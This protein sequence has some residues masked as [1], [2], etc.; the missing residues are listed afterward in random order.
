MSAETCET[1]EEPLV[2]LRYFPRQLITADCMRTEQ[3]YFLD[4]R[5]RHNRYLHGFG[6]SC[7]LDVRRPPDA[8]PER[9][10]SKVW[11][12]PGYAVSPE[13]DDILLDEPVCIDLATGRQQ[14][15]PCCEPWPCPPVGRLPGG[16]R[17]LLTLWLAVRYA[18]CLSRP[19]RVPA[20]GCGCDE[21]ACDYSRIRDSFELK[22]LRALP[23]SHRIA[24]E[25]DEVWK[26]TFRGW[27]DGG[28]EQRQPM[29]VPPCPGCPPDPWVVLA[30]IALRPT[31]DRSLDVIAIRFD[32]RRVLLSTE[33]LQVLHEP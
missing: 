3:A 32:D 25:R 22:A 21:T 9:A 2:R 19:V 13:G 5:R 15:D 16:P 27:R 17:D 1:C 33:A 23:D 7:G 11:V 24:R 20:T 12:C 31:P 28:A 6:V 30:T 4:K 10:G 29:P 18:E 14:P 26:K 8:D